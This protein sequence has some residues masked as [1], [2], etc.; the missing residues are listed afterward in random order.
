MIYLTDTADLEMFKEFEQRV[1]AL[2]NRLAELE[3]EVQPD[4]VI[5]K[6]NEDYKKK[7]T[8]KLMEF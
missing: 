7:L 6:I 8:K 5:R 3:K 1:T 4:G 2:E